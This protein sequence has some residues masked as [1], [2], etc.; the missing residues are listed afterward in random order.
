MISHFRVQEIQR[1]RAIAIIA[2]VLIHTTMAFTKAELYPV[3]FLALILDSA[4]HFAVPLFICISGFVITL[5]AYPIFTFYYRRGL[6]I[7]PAYVGI[8]ILY[9]LCYHKPVID[10][11]LHFNAAYHLS[12]FRYLV[13]LYLLYPLIIKVFHGR[14]ALP[15]ALFMQLLYYEIPAD[16]F[17]IREIEAFSFMQM[18]FYFVLGIYV[19]QNYKK[20]Q[21][22]VMSLHNS[23][24]VLAFF[25]FWGL[26]SMSWLHSYYQL[27]YPSMES[28]S[29]GFIIFYLIE[30]IFIF[31]YSIAFESPILNKIGDYSFGI[32]LIH[33]LVLQKTNKLLLY[34]GIDP[35]QAGFYI[36]GFIITFSVSYF[37]AWCWN[38]SLHYVLEN[39]R[40]PTSQ[41]WK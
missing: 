3:T 6:R 35:T 28:Y 25:I 24:L 30:F 34:S 40:L 26:V 41:F 27:Q 15:A 17:P 19:C 12:F 22:I 8:S 7:I 18:L 38:S 11:M 14:F 23:L 39:E 29:I 5:K 10:S 13:F 21:K 32:F 20:I 9:A 36:I 31:K 4:A 33:P 37:A 1:M 2:V 16:I